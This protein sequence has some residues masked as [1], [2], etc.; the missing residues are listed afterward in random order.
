MFEAAGLIVGTSTSY[1]YSATVPKDL[2]CGTNPP[3]GTTVDEGSTVDL[4]I[5]LG[6]ASVDIP[7]VTGKKE[8]EAE[9]ALTEAG[10]KVAKK[11]EYSTDFAKGIVISQSHTGKA[12]PGA[13][14]TLYISLGK[15][16]GWTVLDGDTYYV[17]ADGTFAKGIKQIDGEYYW[18]DEST[19][20]LQT[21]VWKKISDTWYF[22]GSDGKRYHNSFLFYENDVYYFKTDGTVQYGWF[23]RNS[24]WFYANSTGRL[25]HN[26]WLNSNGKWCYFDVECHMVT[27]AFAVE[28]DATYRFD[29]N[30][31]VVIGWFKVDGKWYYAGRDGKLYK[32]QWLKYN[33]KWYYFDSFG[34]PLASDYVVYN[35]G[36]YWF[37]SNGTLTF[38]WMGGSGTWYY[39]GSNGRLYHNQSIKYGGKT[40]YF[41]SDYKLQTNTNW[42]LYNGRWYYKKSNNSYAV[43]WNR[44]GGNWHYFNGNRSALTGWVKSDGKWYFFG[45]YGRFCANEW[46]SWKGSYYHLDAK[47]NPQTGWQTIDGASYYLGTDGVLVLDDWVESGNTYYRV[48][49]DGKYLTSLSPVVV[50][51]R[52][53]KTSEG[54]VQGLF[55]APKGVSSAPTIVF[56]HGLGGTGTNFMDNALEL[57]GNGIAVYIFD[58]VGGS[59]TSASGGSFQKM[60]IDTEKSQL[61]AI[62][63]EVLTWKEVDS[64]RLYLAGHSQGG[65]L[66]TLIAS[67]RSDIAG[68]VLI[69]PALNLGEL[70]RATFGS[71]DKVPSTFTFLNK[72]LGRAYA[73]ALWDVNV[74]DVANGYTGTSLVFHGLD[75]DII[76][77]SVSVAAYQFWGASCTIHSIPGV[78][79]TSII[80][81]S[82]ELVEQ[83]CAYVKAY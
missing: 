74:R 51:K 29:A 3:V 82:P 9:S 6:P 77:P 60:T 36:V 2:V 8:N 11:Y 67:S 24:Q 26:K 42:V 30:G 58:F 72:R 57:A 69:S 18:F 32:D 70:V 65:L 1:E 47:G 35:G 12:D 49:S 4:V 50:E 41:G 22:F 20:I 78:D 31:H 40:Y 43:G 34:N 54:T 64:H 21:D 73:E 53:V 13:T 71:L 33:N 62:V 61:N 27:S 75:D 14:I 52:S 55:I 39:A 83:I 17:N 16:P 25:Y 5:S 44:I 23:K 76:D 38:G 45:E 68:I 79:H 48:D 28:D 80:N 15:Q 19:G 10:F 66:S 59:P 37:G 56:S 46:I 81:F 63:D 7:N